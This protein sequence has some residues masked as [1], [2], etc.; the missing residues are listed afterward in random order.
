MSVHTVKDD[1]HFHYYRT[2]YSI[3]NI[4]DEKVNRTYKM[5]YLPK[6][7]EATTLMTKY[8]MHPGNPSFLAL[9]DKVLAEIK[10]GK[11]QVPS[12]LIWGYHD[13]VMHH[14][15]GM[16]LFKY[17]TNTDV[18][19]SRLIIFD[20]CNHFPFVE[21][22]ELFNRTITSFCGAYSFKSID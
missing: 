7:I 2:S 17:I 12:L 6:M 21:Y 9:Q 22:P 16:E 5:S 18:P 3:N 10:E 13:A 4:T 14:E 20:N 1:L 15:V 19:G 8:G 11:L